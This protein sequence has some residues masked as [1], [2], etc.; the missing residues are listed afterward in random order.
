MKQ[1][2]KKY[3]DI[4]V[5]HQNLNNSHYGSFHKVWDPLL[6]RIIIVLYG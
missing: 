5:G 1:Q 6:Y 2:K 4:I 3:I